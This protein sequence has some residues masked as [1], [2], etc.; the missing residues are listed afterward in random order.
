V[1]RR[2]NNRTSHV[3]CELVHDSLKVVTQNSLLLS[4]GRECL[5]CLSKPSTTTTRRRR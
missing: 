3:L 4:V 1:T 5:H 2:K